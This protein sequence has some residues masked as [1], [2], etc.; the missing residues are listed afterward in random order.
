MTANI[1][2]YSMVICTHILLFF[3]IL[4]VY[5]LVMKVNKCI[6][7][8]RK[9]G[10]KIKSATPHLSRVKESMF[11]HKYQDTPLCH[12]NVHLLL[13]RVVEGTWP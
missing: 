3:C 12:Q 11:T 13:Q 9:C 2:M 1:T 8:F 4:K 7:T 10:F 5:Y 6:H